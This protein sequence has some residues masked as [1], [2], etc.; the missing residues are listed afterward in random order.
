[1]DKE[2]SSFALFVWLS[3]LERFYNRNM[4]NTAVGS[5]KFLEDWKRK[6]EP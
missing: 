4:L 3:V 1:M 5:F 6:L 2:V